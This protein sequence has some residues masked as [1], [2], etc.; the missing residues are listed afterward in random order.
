MSETKKILRQLTGEVVS[1]KMDKT[2]IVKVERVVKHKI[3]GKQFS[4]SKRYKV[5]DATKQANLGNIVLIEQCR[6]LS[7][8][9]RFRL[10]KV[11]KDRK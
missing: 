6:P 10:I 7:K 1:T 4:V 2:I 3:Y 8:D 5:H 9:K 11:L